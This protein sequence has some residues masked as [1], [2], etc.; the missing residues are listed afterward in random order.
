MKGRSISKITIS[1][2]GI[3]TVTCQGNSKIACRFETVIF[4]H[5]FAKSFAEHIYQIKKHYYFLNLE[6]TKNWPKEEIITTIQFEF[7]MAMVVEKEP[8]K[9][10]GKF[11]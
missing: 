4:S 3:S 8:L 2:H 5:D 9:Y 6:E 11:L 7:L 10:I 1:R